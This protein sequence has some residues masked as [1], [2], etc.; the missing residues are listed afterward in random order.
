MRTI[1]KSV[2]FVP[3]GPTWP[4]FLSPYKQLLLMVVVYAD[5]FKMVGLK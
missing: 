5:D 3:M 1:V 2:G 4:D